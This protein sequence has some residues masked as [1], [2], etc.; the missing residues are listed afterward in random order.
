MCLRLSVTLLTPPH[1]VLAGFSVGERWPGGGAR[2]TGEVKLLLSLS[3]SSS[4]F[5][6]SF[7]SPQ[8]SFSLCLGLFWSSF[9]TSM[10]LAPP[11][12]YT[13]VCVNGLAI[14]QHGFTIKQ[15]IYIYIYS[16]NNFNNGHKGP[17]W[18]N[19]TER[20]KRRL[21][22]MKGHIM[23]LEVLRRCQWPAIQFI[24]LLQLHRK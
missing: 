2:E 10:T 15:N 8:P 5:P 7:F 20:H 23:F 1:Q 11:D 12:M 16:R 24:H 19:F 22:Q 3:S 6:F 13:A 21:L 17:I 18:E 9:T 14:D 4:S